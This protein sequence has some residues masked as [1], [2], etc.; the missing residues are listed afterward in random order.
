MEMRNLVDIMEKLDINKVKIEYTPEDLF[1][2]LNIDNVKMLFQCSAKR[3][4]ISGK[5]NYKCYEG[6]FNNFNMP[7][8]LFIFNDGIVI[9]M[10]YDDFINP[11]DAQYTIWLT[12]YT[13]DFSDFKKELMLPINVV[14][15]NSKKIVKNLNELFNNN[16]KKLIEQI[17]WSNW[18][19][20]G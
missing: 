6:Y 4:D 14:I 20:I 17:D 18:E 8:R 16:N 7:I 5:R 9:F 11:I 13:D 19:Q 12:F 15:K 1:K 2:A 3:A 10:F